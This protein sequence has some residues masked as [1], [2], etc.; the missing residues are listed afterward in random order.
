MRL[1]LLIGK[2]QKI[3]DKFQQISIKFINLSNFKLIKSLCHS[4]S[5]LTHVTPRFPKK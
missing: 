2:I 4:K 5:E 3:P 1:K